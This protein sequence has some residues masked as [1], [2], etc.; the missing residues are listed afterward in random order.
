MSKSTCRRVGTPA[1]VAALVAASLCAPAWA[2]TDEAGQSAVWT[3]RELQFTYMG[4]TTKYTCDGLRDRVKT[5]LLLLGARK[6]DLKVVQ[7][8]CSGNPDRPDPFPGVRIKMHVL[9]PTDQKPTPDGQI[10]AA[11]WQPVD[12][13]KGEFGLDAAGQCELLEQVNQKILPLFATRNIDM[14]TSC[15]PHQLSPA[16]TRLKAE[17]LIADRKKPADKQAAAK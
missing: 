1:L 8:P 16:G 15:V 2:A 12:L 17:V 14:Q 13:L 9:Q 7:S 6:D 3:P 4:F 11:H 5:M 10:V